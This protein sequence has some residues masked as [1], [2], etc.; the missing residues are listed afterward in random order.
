LGVKLTAP[1]HLPG[2]ISYGIVVFFGFMKVYVP[3]PATSVINAFLA[4][5]DP[6]TGEENF[7]VVVPVGQR[8]IPTHIQPHEAAVHFER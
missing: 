6:I 4:S 2:R 3:L 5:L 7:G 1:C 8:S